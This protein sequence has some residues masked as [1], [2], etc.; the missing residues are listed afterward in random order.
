MQAGDVCR[1]APPMVRWLDPPGRFTGSL[2]AAQRLL[3]RVAR[4]LFVAAVQP[5]HSN[6]RTRQPSD[7]AHPQVGAQFAE[8]E[9]DEGVVVDV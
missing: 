1:K 3:L 4:K 8:L 6:R 9:C 7:V 2:P 5:M